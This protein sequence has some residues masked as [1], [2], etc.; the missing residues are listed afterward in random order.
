MSRSPLLLDIPVPICTPRLELREPRPGDGAALNAAIHDSFDAIS[1]WLPWAHTRPSP[2][3]SEEYIRRCAAEWILR[4]ELRILGFERR[5]GKLA[6]NSGLHRIQWDVPS[7]EIGYWVR[8]EFAGQGLVSETV[9]ALTRFAFSALHA[10]RVEIRCD[11]HN[12]RSVAVCTRL[13]FDREAL[14]RRDSL[15]PD[16]RV[17]DTLVF[18]RLSA[19]DLPALAVTW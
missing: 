5:T 12:R 10:K 15:T 9:N 18:A 8:T 13:G 19:D 16:G 17:R 6:V 11:P 14:L 3:E 4:Q 2:D 1:R 7:F